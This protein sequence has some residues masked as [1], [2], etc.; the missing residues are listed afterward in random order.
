VVNGVQVSWTL[1][2]PATYFLGFLAALQL[3][4]IAVVGLLLAGIAALIGA[5]GSRSRS[6][7]VGG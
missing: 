4:I 5:A 7:L 2:E 3:L 6:A 1:P